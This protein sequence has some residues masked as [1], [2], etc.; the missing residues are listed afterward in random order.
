MKLNMDCK[1][2]CQQVSTVHTLVD[3]I[4]ISAFLNTWVAIALGVNEQLFFPYLTTTS[5]HFPPRELDS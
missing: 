3:P 5:M 2:G 1:M 4:T